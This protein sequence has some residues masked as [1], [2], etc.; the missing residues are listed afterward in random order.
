MIRVF[1]SEIRQS[2]DRRDRV[3]GEFHFASAPRVGETIRFSEI[4]GAFDVISVTHLPVSVDRKGGGGI[5]MLVR[6]IPVSD[7]G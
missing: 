4:G 5:S 2:R 1:V 3:E 7:E 6:R